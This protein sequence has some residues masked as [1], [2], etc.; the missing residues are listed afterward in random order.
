VET[1]YKVLVDV[2]KTL[3][4]NEAPFLQYLNDFL[5]EHHGEALLNDLETPPK[6]VDP[7]VPVDPYLTGSELRLDSDDVEG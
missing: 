1:G 3:Y 4:D 6:N 7:F 2:E 5:E